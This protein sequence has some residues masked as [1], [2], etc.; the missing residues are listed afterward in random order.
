MST[1][2]AQPSMAMQEG[3]GVN[4]YFRCI[5]RLKS[6]KSQ[7]STYF[8]DVSLLVYLPLS[9]C[10]R[11]SRFSTQKFLAKPGH[12][13]HME[14]I[15]AALPPTRIFKLGS[16]DYILIYNFLR[17]FFFFAIILVLIG[18]YPGES[19]PTVYLHRDPALIEHRVCLAKNFQGRK[20]ALEYASLF[21]SLPHYLNT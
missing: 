4:R 9:E 18:W 19:S 15:I 2:A 1:C 16:I 17:G 7:P 14:K 12:C 3:G 8:T 6:L 10:R 11:G 5:P 13:D 21:A 20:H